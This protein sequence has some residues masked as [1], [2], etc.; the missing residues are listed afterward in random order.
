MLG[1]YKVAH[2]I[3]VTRGRM[4]QFRVVEEKLTKQGYI[5]FAPVI[6]T[7]DVYMEYADMIDDMCNEKLQ[8]ADLLVIVTPDHIG[9]STIFRINQAKEKGIPVYVFENNKLIPYTNENFS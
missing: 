9:K 6:Y 4:H 2:L 3:G 5:C 1:K 8:I 7:Y